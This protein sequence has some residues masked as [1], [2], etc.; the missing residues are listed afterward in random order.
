[1]PLGFMKTMIRPSPH[2]KTPTDLSNWSHNIT[3][4]YPDNA[5]VA[6][7]VNFGP[8]TISIP[9][10][11][12]ANLA[13]GLCAIFAWKLQLRHKW[14]PHPLGAKAHHL[15][16]AQMHHHPP[17]ALIKHAN[18]TV[19]A[20]NHWYSVV[21]YSTSRLFCFVDNGFMTDGKWFEQA[22]DKQK[23]K[24]EAKRHV[25]VKEGIAR[26]STIAELMAENNT[27]ASYVSNYNPIVPDSHMLTCYTQ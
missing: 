16:P 10:Y 8:H 3:Q 9:H 19:A 7:S 20:D 27:M 21:Q 18:M 25:R 15:L 23:A 6:T 17:S 12:H 1:M 4:N 24:R 14:P 26:L 2:D 13:W 11:D 5:F 22:T